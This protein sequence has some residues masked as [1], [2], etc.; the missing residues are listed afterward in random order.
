MPLAVGSLTLVP[1]VAGVP[2]KPGGM[3]DP[4][5]RPE[6]MD[7]EGPGEASTSERRTDAAEPVVV[8]YVACGSSHSLALLSA[9]L[10]AGY[11][12]LCLL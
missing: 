9:F 2:V 10:K 11:V 1:G 3:A 5:D 7:T 8:T 6:P 12:L 4:E